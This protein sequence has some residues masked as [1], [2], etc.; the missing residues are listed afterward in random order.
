MTITCMKFH[1]SLNKLHWGSQCQKYVVVDIIKNIKDYQ[2]SL[3]ISPNTSIFFLKFLHDFAS[4]AIKRGFHSD[5]V[6]RL[7]KLKPEHIIRM[8][9]AFSI[10]SKS[11]ADHR[12]KISSHLKFDEEAFK[13]QVQ[14]ITKFL[15][16]I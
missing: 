7:L 14:T 1:H 12:S 13:N 11:I 9:Q 6:L 4:P 16:I 10:C 5:Q 2:R 15:G 8:R 3:E